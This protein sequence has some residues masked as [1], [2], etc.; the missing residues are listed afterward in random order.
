M[1]TEQITNCE[2]IINPFCFDKLKQF[3]KLKLGIKS[4]TQ[5]N[6]TCP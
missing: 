6:L 5:V 4:G 1:H 2:S 3:N